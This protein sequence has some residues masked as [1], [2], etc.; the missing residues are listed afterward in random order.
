MNRF[1]P[2]NYR[3]FVLTVWRDQGAAAEEPVLRF[4]LH[5]PRS[6]QRRGFGESEVLLAFLEASLDTSADDNQDP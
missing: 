5:D 3:I 4:S 2:T 1:L 6:G